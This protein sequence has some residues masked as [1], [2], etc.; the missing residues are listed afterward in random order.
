MSFLIRISKYL[1]IFRSRHHQLVYID[2]AESLVSFHLMDVRVT[3]VSFFS[4]QQGG[5]GP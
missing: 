4:S 2:R 5:D 1:R 3:N